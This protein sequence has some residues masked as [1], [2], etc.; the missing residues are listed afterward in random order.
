MSKYVRPVLLFTILVY[1]IGSFLL[2]NN[3]LCL[4]YVN[5]TI[6]TFLPFRLYTQY[7]YN[8]LSGNSKSSG[9]YSY[10]ADLLFY[11]NNYLVKF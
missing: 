9:L 7:L 4:A 10:F 6:L 5:L 2:L 8:K 11:Q 1:Y 3:A